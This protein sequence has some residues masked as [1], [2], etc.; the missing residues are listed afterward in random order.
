M[1]QKFRIYGDTEISL[2]SLLFQL[3]ILTICISLS[4]FN[5]QF[6]Y[7]TFAITVFTG[8]LN[9]NKY[10]FCQ[11]FFLLPFTVI[12]KLSPESSSFFAYLLLVISFFLVARYKLKLVILLP[13]SIYTL[14]GLCDNLTMWIKLMSGW[15]L[16]IY[17]IKYANTNLVKYVSL[18]S[19]I[20]LI[21]SSIW[22]LVKFDIPQLANY[23]NEGNSEYMMGERIERFSGLYYDP[24]YY[25]LSVAMTLY[26]ILY[27]GVSNNLD[28]KVA[29][30]IAAILLC[31]G[32]LSY[33]KMF[34]F[35]AFYILVI[36]L[37]NMI[38]YSKNKIRLIIIITMVL[39][40]CFPLF[41]ESNYMLNFM[42]RFTTRDFSSG[43]FTL[44]EIY[45]TY[46]LSNFDVLMF[47]RGIG[48]EIVGT[49][50]PHNTFVE[51]L[52]FLGIIGTIIYITTLCKIFSYNKLIKHKTPMNYSLFIVFCF[53]IGSLCMLTM[54]D[55]MFLLMLLWFSLNIDFKMKK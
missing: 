54:N 18:S 36:L 52:Y 9:K 53:M 38:F 13:I 3:L 48:G 34:F 14:L 28:K 11:L 49:H 5:K 30:P 50:V 22:G 55:F 43:R 2:K 39:F 33:S 32:A 42:D 46:I 41:L 35:V 6:V 16:L 8:L 40:F 21:I 44:I 47:G 4:I 37:K 17:F 7:A 45:M 24:N 26:M 29:F 19:S 1:E 27:F 12:Y 15:V 25:S 23:I 20:G 10:V 31:F 51:I